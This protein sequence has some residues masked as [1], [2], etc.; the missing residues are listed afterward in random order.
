MNPIINRASY[1]VRRRSFAM[2]IKVILFSLLIAVGGFV[3]TF[4][5]A[6]Q[7]EDVRGA[8]LTTRPKATPKGSKPA[9]TVK[10]SRRR[11]RATATNSAGA[12]R[13]VQKSG[14]TPT[15]GTPAKVN[16]A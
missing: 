3:P 15:A 12:D 8:Y 4:A 10:P 16:T 5:F 7:D 14:S 6:Q 13:V 2:R 1:L 11:P 9:T